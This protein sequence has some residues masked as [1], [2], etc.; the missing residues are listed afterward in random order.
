MK[1]IFSG[2]EVFGAK[3]A[4]YGDR[5]YRIVT[6]FRNMRNPQKSQQ[7]QRADLRRYPP[8]N[9]GL[10]QLA[11]EYSRQRID[12]HRDRGPDSRIMREICETQKRPE[13]QHRARRVFLET[14]IQT[15]QRRSQEQQQKRIRPYFRRKSDE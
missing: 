9:R 6:Q 5:L 4:I 12:S 8:E 3:P 14:S 15:P 1:D 13:K 2:L 11:E 10:L 7:D